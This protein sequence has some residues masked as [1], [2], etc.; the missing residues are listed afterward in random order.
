MD[1]AVRDH[2]KGR[3]GTTRQ[4]T[5]RLVPVSKVLHLE[6]R[7]WVQL[8][9][10]LPPDDRYRAYG[11][12]LLL[13]HYYLNGG[14]DRQ[15]VVRKMLEQAG[16]RGRPNEMVDEA[17]E[18]IEARLTKFWNKRDLPLEFALSEGIK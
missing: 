2:L 11:T 16:R 15:Q 5:I 12:A 13:T 1:A 7:G 9:E 3:L 10:E 4:P 14:P 8:M 18:E 6:G 17:P